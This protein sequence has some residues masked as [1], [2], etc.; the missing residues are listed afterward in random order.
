MLSR[1]ERKSNDV[2][3]RGREREVVQ[4]IAVKS[5][6]HEMMTHELIRPVLIVE[7]MQVVLT[8]H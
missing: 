5:V 2:E 4:D 7:D 8:C 3:H 6:R 1:V